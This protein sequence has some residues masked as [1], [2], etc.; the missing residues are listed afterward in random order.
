VRCGDCFAE[1]N[2]EC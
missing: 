1:T 2:L